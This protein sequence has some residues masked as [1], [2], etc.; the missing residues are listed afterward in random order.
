MIKEE[1]LDAVNSYSSTPDNANV[2]W[3]EVETKY[4]EKSRHYHTLDHLES[5]IKELLP[6]KATF[7][8]WSVVVF[9]AV[10]HDIIYKATKTNNEERSAALAVQRLKAIAAP[11]ELIRR[12]REFIV[13]TKRH[14]PADN[15]IDH[16][17][18]ADLSIL[19]SSPDT[20]QSYTKQIRKEYSIYPDLFYKPGRKKVL[21]HFLGMPHIYKSTF[22][23]DK[24]ETAAR[25]NL[26]DELK[27]LGVVNG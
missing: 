7:S 2:L 22:F 9:A 23:R 13:A 8:N 12:C 21:L 18:D 27:G 20:Y 14:E 5:L 4:A 26:N 19:G 25:R 11:P 15:E 10:Y 1:F 24:Y 17:T 3:Q 6:V 16:F